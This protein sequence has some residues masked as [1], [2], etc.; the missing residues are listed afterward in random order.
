MTSTS[1]CLAVADLHRRLVTKS[2][3]GL[4]C[5]VVT[6]RR[7]GRRCIWAPSC[8]AVT[9]A[10]PKSNQPLR[11]VSNLRVGLAPQ[12]QGGWIRAKT[13]EGRCTRNMLVRIPTTVHVQA[14]TDLVTATS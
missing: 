13:R 1:T 3:L 2:Y 14:G 8:I 10:C 12:T 6:N 9:A 4:N 5:P 7:G 11:Q